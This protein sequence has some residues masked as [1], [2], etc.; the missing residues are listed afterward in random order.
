MSKAI[1]MAIILLC[2]GNTFAQHP[3]NL[4]IKDTGNKPLPAAT[5][6]ILNTNKTVVA[7][8]S[9]IINFSSVSPGTYSIKISYV[10]FKDKLILITVPQPAESIP[11]VLL[12]EDE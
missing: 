7:D 1:I 4:K 5:A 6:L 10:H 8:S 11:D 9:G 3:I 2:A 12:E